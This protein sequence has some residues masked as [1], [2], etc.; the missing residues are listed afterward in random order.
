MADV[1][2][3]G[4]GGKGDSRDGKGMAQL[5]RDGTSGKDGTGG[6]D[7]IAGKG[8]H[9]WKGEWHSW[10]GMAEPTL[11]T[12]LRF[13]VLLGAAEAVSELDSPRVPQGLFL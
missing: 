13:C 12:F 10:E 6:K 8:W 11:I 4:T 7:G 1:G 2:K 5:E 9:R 3:D